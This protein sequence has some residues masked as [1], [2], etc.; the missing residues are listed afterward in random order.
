ML[1]L[2][3]EGRLIVTV[4]RHGEVSQS[5]GLEARGPLPHGAARGFYGRSRLA[6]SR[7]CVGVVPDHRRNACVNALGSA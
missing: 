3:Q 1:V 7:H 5:I 2:A 6:D 4:H